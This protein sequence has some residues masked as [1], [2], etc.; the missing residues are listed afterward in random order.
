MMQVKVKE[1]KESRMTN[2]GKTAVTSFKFFESLSS[3]S[4]VSSINNYQC[5]R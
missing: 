3:E 5:R 4:I 1:Q 2:C